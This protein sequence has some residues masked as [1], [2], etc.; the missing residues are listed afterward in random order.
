MPS[1]EN[2]ES[3]KINYEESIRDKLNLQFNVH[4]HLDRMSSIITNP[5]L[6]EDRYNWAIEHLL[7][8]L[9]PYGD[10]KF[11]ENYNKIERDYEKKIKDI[12]TTQGEQE[13]IKE[14]NRKVLIELSMLIKRLR[15]GL[16]IQGSEE[17]GEADG[18]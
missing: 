7:T 3:N 10:E 5:Q 4:R 11:T 8:M 12:K 2:T 1:K 14:K 9:I 15:L 17:I 13:L 16:E 18:T 6:D